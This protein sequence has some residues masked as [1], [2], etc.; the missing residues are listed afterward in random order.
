MKEEREVLETFALVSKSN[1]SSQ[2]VGSICFA[3]P[4]RV[5]ELKDIH[6]WKENSKH[7]FWENSVENPYSKF[8]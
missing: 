8:L 4:K 7:H 6:Y 3:W 1:E 5:S 2:N